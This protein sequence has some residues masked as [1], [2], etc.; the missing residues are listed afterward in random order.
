MGD[1]IGGFFGEL[2]AQ[3][4]DGNPNL[5]VADFGAAVNPV[6]VGGDAPVDENT[7]V[8]LV[9]KSVPQGIE[10][11]TDSF[12][13]KD[14][15]IITKQNIVVK[16]SKDGQCDGGVYEPDGGEI[17]PEKQKMK[18]GWDNHFDSFGKQNLDAIMADYTEDSV[19]RVYDWSEESDPAQAYKVHTGLTA[20]RDLFEGLF[21]VI[22]KDTVGAPVVAE[23]YDLNS[24]FLVWTSNAW[25]RATDTFL[26]N[27]DGKI[28]QQNVVVGGKSGSRAWGVT[29]IV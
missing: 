12:L 14:G 24:V 20:I 16:D 1:A 5:T 19:V 25:E 8:F 27:N 11:A 10:E 17:D 22:N 7:N 23:E 21:D 26:F 28:V 13:W 3:L 6:V 2:F 29:A 9:W 18:D 4:G 15:A